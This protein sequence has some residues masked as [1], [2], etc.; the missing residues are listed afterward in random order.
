MSKNHIDRTRY[1]TVAGFTLLELLIVL[2]LVSLGYVSLYSA[3]QE[4]SQGSSSFETTSK[5]A[6]TAIRYA[7]NFALA[8]GRPVAITIK[9]SSVTL[10]E[11]DLS[12]PLQSP[13]EAKPYSI[14]APDNF[15]FKQG[16]IETIGSKKLDQFYFDNQGRLG[17][18]EQGSN[19]MS[20]LKS[21]LSISYEDSS[22]SRATQ[23]PF[24]EISNVTGEIM[25][26]KP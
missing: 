20:P 23:H 1:I 8:S 12:T 11:Q 4:P 14:S 16:T 9:P 24:M 6:I 7:R 2:F 15:S 22:Q 13:T 25:P 17:S 26:P 10:T 3:R 21:P 5:E 19:V 18:F